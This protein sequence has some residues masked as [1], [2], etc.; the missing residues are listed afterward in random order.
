MRRG[1]FVTSDPT[2]AQRPQGKGRYRLLVVSHPCVVPVNQSV[3]A[4]LGDCNWEIDIVVPAAWRHPYSTKMLSPEPLPELAG[5]LHTYKVALAGNIQGHAYLA[6]PRRAIRNF[7]PNVVFIEQEPFAVSSLQW[8]QAA[9]RS[10]IPFGFQCDENLDR[11]LPILARAIRRAA[12]PRAA[13]VAARS[14][15]AADLMRRKGAIG[16]VQVVPHAVPNWGSVSNGR[17]GKEEFTIGYAGRLVKEKGVLDLVDAVGRLGN[18]CRLLFV[19]SG[20]LAEE[21]GAMSSRERPIQVEQGI[22][23]T[24]MPEFYRQMDLLVLPSRT[25]SGWSEQFGRVLVEANSCGIPVIGSDS[26]EIPWVIGVTKGGQTFPEGNVDM[27]SAVIREFRGSP[28]LREA[29]GRMG[30]VRTIEHFG[31]PAVARSLDA[32]LRSVLAAK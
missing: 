3:Y 19:G 8:A 21:L 14:P 28:S 1:N 24:S 4:A 32:V 7:R 12:L 11:R 2:A 10:A 13:F 16:Q 23:H 25:T 27:L 9:Q 18:P 5:K 6:F 30:R 22:S 29:Y 31:A 17:T 20:P 15:R 26:G